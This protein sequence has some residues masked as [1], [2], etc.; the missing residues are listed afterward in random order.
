MIHASFQAVFFENK[1]AL[2]VVWTPAV[3]RDSKLYQFF[4]REEIQIKK[5][6]EVLGLL[7]SEKLHGSCGW[8]PWEDH[9]FIDDRSS[10]KVSK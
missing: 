9:H 5:R 2:L 10:L 6:S 1:E 3:P 7:S 4:E 8:Y